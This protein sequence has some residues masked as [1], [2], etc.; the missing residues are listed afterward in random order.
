MLMKTEAVIAF[1]LMILYPD[2]FSYLVYNPSELVSKYFSDNKNWKNYSSFK[3][4]FFS[5]L[6]II[7]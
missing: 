5:C 2:F 3:S 6:L 7:T 4:G 1:W